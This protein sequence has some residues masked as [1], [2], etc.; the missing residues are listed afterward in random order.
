MPR[1]YYGKRKNGWGLTRK[2]TREFHEAHWAV[3]LEETGED[4][5]VHEVSSGGLWLGTLDEATGQDLTV[6][7]QPKSV[8]KEA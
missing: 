2:G 6:D 3:P 1:V 8:R 7:P 4:V 5:P